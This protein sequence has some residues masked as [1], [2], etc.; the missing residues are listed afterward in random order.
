M[1]AQKQLNSWLCVN[2]ERK[3]MMVKVLKLGREPAGVRG[4]KGK[5]QT[6]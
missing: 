4:G 3:N 5:L 2:D 6:R 1:G